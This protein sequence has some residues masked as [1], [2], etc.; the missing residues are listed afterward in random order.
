MPITLTDLNIKADALQ[1]S[2]NAEQS[3]ISNKIL[4]LERSINELRDL[5]A[6]APTEAEMQAFADKL[7]A[8]KLDV[9]SSITI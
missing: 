8:I 6:A 1:A 4:E 3:F 9:D 2:I 5:V 7:D